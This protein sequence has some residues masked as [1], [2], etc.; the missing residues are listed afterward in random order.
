[1][2]SVNKITLLGRKELEFTVSGVEYVC[3]YLNPKYLINRVG[4]VDSVRYSI[5]TPERAIADILHVS[6]KY[7]FDNTMAVEKLDI[8]KI[9]KEIGYT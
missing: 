4:I 3:K 5:A 2:Q 1:M 9:S 7:H 8:N 6:P